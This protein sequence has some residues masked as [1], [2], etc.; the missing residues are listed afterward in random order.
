MRFKT[1][2][3]FL[4]A[5]R[6]RIGCG[7]WAIAVGI[8]WGSSPVEAGTMFSADYRTAGSVYNVS[9]GS[10]TTISLTGTQGQGLTGGSIIDLAR[11]TLSP[12]GGQAPREVNANFSLSLRF[13]NSAEPGEPY[14]LPLVA[15]GTITGTVGGT[16]SMLHVHFDPAS[17]PLLGGVWPGTPLISNDGAISVGSVGQKDPAGLPLL[18][19]LRLDRTDFDLAGRSDVPLTLDLTARFE[20]HPVPEPTVVA[21]GV[22]ALGGYHLRRRRRRPD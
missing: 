17:I 9:D 14:N 19:L 20:V 16:N 13:L 7:A 2:M 18:G 22:V 5:S 6:R 10:Q 12:T 11:L 3:S 8:G 4:A 15:W 21:L 1:K